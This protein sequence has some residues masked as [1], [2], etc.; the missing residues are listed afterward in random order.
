M[1]ITEQVNGAVEPCIYCGRSTAFGTG[2]GLFVNRI[3]ADDG[4]ACA[5]CISYECDEC[6]NRIDLDD[7]LRVEYTD[8]NG[9]FH[10]GNYHQDCY[11]TAKHGPAVTYEK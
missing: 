9:I 6:G 2:F 1:N 8:N 4:W 5:D 10:Y 7:E 3:P 11:N